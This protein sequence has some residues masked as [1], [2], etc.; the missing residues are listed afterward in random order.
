MVLLSRNEDIDALHP[1]LE[2]EAEIVS[3]N[4]A[5]QFAF[6]GRIVWKREFNE[7]RKAFASLGIEFSPGV[8][9]PRTLIDA[10][11]EEPA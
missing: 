1:P 7:G 9:L 5:L 8:K 6:R 4:T 11:A 2:I 3:E 10:V